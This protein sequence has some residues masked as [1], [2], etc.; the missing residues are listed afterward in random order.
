LKCRIPTYSIHAIFRWDLGPDH[1]HCLGP[2]R[3]L[4]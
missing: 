1:I 3:L 2:S 4:Y